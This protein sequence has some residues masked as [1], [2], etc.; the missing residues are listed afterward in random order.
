MPAVKL[1]TPMAEEASAGLVTFSLEGVEP[2]K[3]VD[4]LLRE[5]K[6]LVRSLPYPRALR[7]SLHFFNTE[8]EIEAVLRAL[9]ELPR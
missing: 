2:E 3:A 5:R 7:A 1:Y 4:W 9:R 6:I 8:E